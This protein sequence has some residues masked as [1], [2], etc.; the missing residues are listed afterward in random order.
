[1]LDAT[2]IAWVVPAGP[3]SPSPVS[4]GCEFPGEL[5]GGE[6]ASGPFVTWHSPHECGKDLTYGRLRSDTLAGRVVRYHKCGVML[7]DRCPAKNLPR[8]GGHEAAGFNFRLD[9]V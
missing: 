1:M 8:C 3:R 2:V 7:S 4:A 5:T 9:H 6:Q